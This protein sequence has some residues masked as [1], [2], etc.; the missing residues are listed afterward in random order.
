MSLARAEQYLQD[1]QTESNLSFWQKRLQEA[2]TAVLSVCSS[3]EAAARSRSALKDAAISCALRAAE[4]LTAMLE[5]VDALGKRLPVQKG[6]FSSPEEE[7]AAFWEL[8]HFL[9]AL[10]ANGRYLREAACS[11]LSCAEEAQKACLYA[12]R[13]ETALRH[14]LAAAKAVQH[15]C[16]GAAE[17]ALD[18]L[19]ALR[20]TA[21][22]CEETGK[23]LCLS[24][25][26]RAEAYT[27]AFCTQAS[28]AADLEHAGKACSSA[29]LRS[30]AEEYRRAL[31]ALQAEARTILNRL[32]EA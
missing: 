5:S 24:L 6:F 31:L 14:I 12:D 30:C 1:G 25:G 22:L 28:L 11:S 29:R 17:R 7:R 23:A 15:D 10:E 2:P 20:R 21:L 3:V 13:E 19:L 9:T 16:L 32:E 18:E 4:G 8:C 27:R 26:D